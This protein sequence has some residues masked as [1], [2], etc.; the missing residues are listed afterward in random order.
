[1]LL[2]P[3]PYS[4]SVE[5]RELLPFRVR[6]VEGPQ[7]LRRA[8][9]IRSS[10]FSRHVPTLGAVLREPEADDYRCDVLLLIVERKADRQVLGTMR[11]QPNILRPLR[12]EG[13]V[14]LPAAYEGARL[15]EFMRLGVENG[16]AG[17]MVMAALAKAGYEI[18]A[19]AGFDSILAVGRRSTSEMYRSM[20]LD[21]VFDGRTVP[22]S[23]AEGRPHSIFALPVADADRR[24]RAANH[25]LY[26]FMARTEHPDIQI[27][28]QRV[29]DAFGQT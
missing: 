2:P 5:S 20:Q 16:N 11:L 27:D 24:W 25:S 18:S 6:I 22:I 9:E 17:R 3:R 23:Y 13:E 14:K 1:M 28:Y 7:D 12:V 4:A 19:A 10:A 26:G 29:F 15:I 21:D 8:V